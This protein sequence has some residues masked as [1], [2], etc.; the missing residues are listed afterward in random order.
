MIQHE[1]ERIIVHS[2]IKCLFWNSEFTRI[3]HQ[4]LQCLFDVHQFNLGRPSNLVY[5]GK[6]VEHLRGLIEDKRCIHCK[7]QLSSQKEA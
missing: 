4:Y 2:D 3:L 5:I 1:N 6:L 7:K